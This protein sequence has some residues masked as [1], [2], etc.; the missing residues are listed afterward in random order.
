MAPSKLI[1]PPSHPFL[2]ISLAIYD[3]F[4][5]RVVSS[6]DFNN[7]IDEKTIEDMFKIPL[8]NMRC[9]NNN[10][11]RDYPTSIITSPINNIKMIVSSFNVTTKRESVCIHLDSF[12]KTMLFSIHRR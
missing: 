10:T 11:F 4:G 7:K 2:S 8:L 9:Q 6:W 1:L 5:I 12:S 3:S